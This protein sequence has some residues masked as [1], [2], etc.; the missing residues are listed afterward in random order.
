M[1]LNTS[2]TAIASITLGLLSG[3]VQAVEKGDWYVRIGASN[4]APNDSSTGFT[5][6]PTVGAAFKVGYL[7][8]ALVHVNV[9]HLVHGSPSNHAPAAAADGALDTLTARA[10]VVVVLPNVHLLNLIMGVAAVTA[11]RTLPV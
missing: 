11:V 10:T 6:A 3:S 2:L 8:A 5:G 1:K 9:P 7:P 4:V